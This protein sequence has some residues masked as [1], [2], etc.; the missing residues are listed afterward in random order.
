MKIVTWNCNGALRNKFSALDR[1]DADLLVIQECE[2]PQNYPGVYLDWAG[3][4]LWV[5]DNKH[6]GLGVFARH[7]N[8]VSE[9]SWHGKFTLAG[10]NPLH[11]NTTWSTADLKLFLPSKVNDDLSILAVW[12]K[13][14]KSEVFRYIGQLW[15]Y[16]QI[17]KNE[18]AMPNTLIIGDL[19]SN[20][21]WDKKDR[22][23]S[24]SGVVAELSELGIHSL[25]HH[26]RQEEQGAEK[27]PTF[28]LQRNLNRAY[29]IDYAFMSAD[30]LARSTLDIGLQETWL[31][32]SDHLPL[33]ITI[34]P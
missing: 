19:N 20:A 32:L 21:I 6:K 17:H 3:H 23:W 29:H 22:W 7:G 11:P 31:T 8:R 25:Y 1:L 9:L 15:K 33:M 2:D 4:Y 14:S 12:T 26:A 5:G 24:H 30:L 18:L 16:I 13:G 27:E 34:T 10:L 28:F